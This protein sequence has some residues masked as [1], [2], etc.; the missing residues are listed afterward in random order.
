MRF[1]VFPAA[2]VIGL[3][4]SLASPAA[5]SPAG[6][7]LYKIGAPKAPT[8]GEVAP[9]LLLV[10]GG[11]WPATAFR[12]FTDKA[13]NGRLVILRA[14]GAEEAGERFY[15]DIGGLTS[16]QTLVF[17]DVKAAHDPRV[18]AL[19]DQADGIFIAG[20]DQANYVRFWKNTPV[21][22]ALNRHVARG[23][24]IGGTSAGLAI[25]GSAAYGA[26]DGG[27]VD[28]QEALKDPMGPAM[29]LVT[30]FLDIPYLAHVVTDTHFAARDRLGRLIAFVA[31][32]RA[33]TDPLAMGLGV[34]EDGALAVEGNGLGRFYHDDVGYVW[35]VQ[36]EGQPRAVLGQPLSYDHVRITTLGTKGQI[37]LNTMTIDTPASEGTAS[38]RDGHLINVPVDP[39]SGPSTP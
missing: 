36:P 24:P 39:R 29:T 34:D 6:Y 19:L 18:L 4:L 27:S 38:V 23:R 9:G 13:G 25:L 15:R 7:R 11:D 37:D 33:T 22:D 20:G 31:H 32:V 3:V 28:T 35:L 12:W 17:D 8:P 2:V 14:S 16:V 30:D 26:M 10:G 1:L 5:A 21:Q